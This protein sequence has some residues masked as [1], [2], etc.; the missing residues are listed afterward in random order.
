MKKIP[1]Y[2]LWKVW[3]AEMTLLSTIEFPNLFHGITIPVDR[4]AFTIFGLS[5]YWYGIFV[6]AAVVLAIA[7]A[8][9]L[10]QHA[11]LIADNVFEIAFWGVITGVIGARAYFV[12]FSAQ[13]YTFTQAV[14][15][16]R[17]GGLAIYGGLIGAIAGGMLAAKIKRVKFSALADLIGLGFLIGHTIGRWGNFFNQEAFGTPTAGDLPW[18][19]T[20]N[21][22]YDFLLR[23]QLITTREFALVHP[24]F[25]YESL[26]CFVGFVVLHFYF[27]KWRSFD[28]E[29]FLLYIIWYGAG[30]AWIEPLRLDSLMAGGLRISQ[31]TAIA[32]AVLALFL[33]IWFK[34]KDN[35]MYKDTEE[36]KQAISGYKYKVRLE[37]EKE[38]AKIALKK[39]RR[40]LSD[41]FAQNILQDGDDNDD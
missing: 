22:I 17:D 25:L 13:A 32:S 18:G 16:I 6:T 34:R 20:G 9:K 36:S 38:R 7:Y 15:G 1:A 35:I 14:F 31:V 24:C 41:P 2:Q 19:M 26:W 3:R 28:G 10:A 33:F 37:K 27:K 5:V 29:V 4:V 12:I 40:E 21:V 23:E 39:T 8:V 11:G 30:R